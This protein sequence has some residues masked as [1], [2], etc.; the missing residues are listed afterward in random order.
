MRR[1]SAAEFDERTV[2]AGPR[3]EFDGTWSWGAASLSADQ[4]RVANDAYDRFRAAEGRSLFGRYADTGLTPTVRAVAEDLEFGQLAPN[5]GQYALLA[6]DT[7]RARF[8]DLLARHP[9][10]T[11][12]RLVRRVPGAISYSFVFEGER[13]SAGSWIVQD[14]LTARGFRLLARRNDWNSAADRCVATMWHDPASDLPFEVQFHTAASLEAQ[15]LA[16]TCESLISDPRI[17]PAEAANLRSDV[18]AAWAAVPAPPGNG[19][20]DDFG[21][22]ATGP[23]VASF[24][25]LDGPR[26]EL[27]PDRSTPVSTDAD[28]R[29]PAG[30][31][32]SELPRRWPPPSGTDP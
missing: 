19:Q 28:D 24:A 11:P 17:P 31:A 6:P 21:R 9:D 26:S 32:S 8:A 23:P 10:R 13:Y 5:A 12:E 30:S 14:A 16:R 29:S 18:D 15:Q 27:S 3:T 1:S 20:I 7:F 2:V 22:G 25:G 4:A